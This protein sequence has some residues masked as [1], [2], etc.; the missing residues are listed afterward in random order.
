MIST[1]QRLAG[2]NLIRALGWRAEGERP[3]ARKAV[4]IAAPHTS[5]LDG[6]LLVAFAW[7]FGLDIQWMVKQSVVQ[8]PGLGHLVTRLGGVPVDRS[9]SRDLVG[10]T[11]DAFARRDSLLVV[12]SP[13][14]TRSRREHWKSGFYWIAWR[15]KVPIV[16]SFL[17][18]RRRVGGFGPTLE[19]SG[20]MARDMDRLRAFYGPIQ[21][22]HPERMTPIRLEREPSC[23]EPYARTD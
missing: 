22:R 11:V 17:D 2:Q 9:K 5:N 16:C 10:A 14:G 21:G 15:A 8:T 19:L 3:Q 7:S 13:P 20:D 18:Y 23:I 4:V 1:S 12:V 6:V